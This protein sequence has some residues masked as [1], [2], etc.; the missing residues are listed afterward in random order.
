MLKALFLFAMLMPAAA[1]A[2][3]VCRCMNGENV[4]ICESTLDMP[5]LCPPKVCPLAPPSLP[6]LSAPTLPPL[7]T[8]DC[9]QQQVYNPATGRYEW[10]QICR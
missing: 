6:P 8:R 1:Q 7:G 4:P 9:T 3:C 5:P 2:A 10:R